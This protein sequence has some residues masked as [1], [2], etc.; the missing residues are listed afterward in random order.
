MGN[1][2]HLYIYTVL[3]SFSLVA[4]VIH[5][6]ERRKHIGNHSLHSNYGYFELTVN[7]IIDINISTTHFHSLQ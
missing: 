4:T 6:W 3:Y 2:F 1:C 5:E 7:E